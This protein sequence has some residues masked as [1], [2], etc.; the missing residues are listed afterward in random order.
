VKK[1]K[2]ALMLLMT[3]PAWLP[4]VLFFIIY[5]LIINVDK[6]HKEYDEDD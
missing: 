4:T 6:V 2:Q 3:V 1:L 5:S